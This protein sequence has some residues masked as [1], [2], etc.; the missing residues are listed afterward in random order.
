MAE[1]SR[2]TDVIEITSNPLLTKRP[3]R[4]LSGL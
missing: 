1:P 3:E 4:Y 2:A